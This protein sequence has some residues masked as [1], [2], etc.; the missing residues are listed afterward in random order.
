LLVTIG[1]GFTTAL[2]ND[3]RFFELRWWEFVISEINDNRCKEAVKGYQWSEQ[4][5][6]NRLQ[7][8]TFKSEHSL[9]LYLYPSKTYLCP[10]KPFLILVRIPSTNIC[11]KA[12]RKVTY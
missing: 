8:T 4:L 9:R 10:S 7:L 12:H 3:F 2:E 6:A 5:L 1:K 11:G